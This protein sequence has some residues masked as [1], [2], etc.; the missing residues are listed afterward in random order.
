MSDTYPYASVFVDRFTTMYRQRH[1]AAVELV[2]RG[3]VHMP[4]RVAT[5]MSILDASDRRLGIHSSTAVALNPRHQSAW[6]PH[7]TT[8]YPGQRPRG[9]RWQENVQ[10]W[11]QQL[12]AYNGALR[13]R[14]GG[15]SA[16]HARISYSVVAALPWSEQSGQSPCWNGF[17]TSFYQPAGQRWCWLARATGPHAILACGYGF[18]SQ[19]EGTADYLRRVTGNPYVTALRM[20]QP[21]DVRLDRLFNIWKGHHGI[22]YWNVYG[23][24]ALYA[25]QLLG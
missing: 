10:Y 7:V 14:V 15:S 17:G 25:A 20:T 12:R 8:Y 4:I 3:T 1:P 6:M 21:Q 5:R 2:G 24:L 22:D 16:A 18:T 13:G 9:A 19:A 11:V 23:N